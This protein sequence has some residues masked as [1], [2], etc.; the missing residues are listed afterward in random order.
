MK[1]LLKRKDILFP[2]LSYEVVGSAFDVYNEIGPGHL[3]KHYQGALAISFRSKG[4]NVKEQLYCP[5]TFMGKMIG[6]RLLDFLIDDAVVVEIKKGNRFSKSHIDQ[7]L[8]YLK[9]NNLKLAIL[10]NFGSDGVLFKR[11]VNFN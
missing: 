7:V 5:V 9:I 2:K 11:V 4:F 6:K 1:T 8:D 3:E 10:V